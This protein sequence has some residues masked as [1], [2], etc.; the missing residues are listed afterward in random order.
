[1]WIRS[2]WP[3]QEIREAFLEE[4]GFER[5]KGV[6][7]GKD[8]REWHFWD[9]QQRHEGERLENSPE[10]G[11]MGTRMTTQDMSRLRGTEARA[12]RAEGTL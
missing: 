2:I 9:R 6:P 3:V 12:L 10:G 1:M 7:P 8:F 4:M 5:C 11:M